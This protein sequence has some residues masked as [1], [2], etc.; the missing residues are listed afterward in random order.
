VIFVDSGVSLRCHTTCISAGNTFH[1]IKSALT[2]SIACSNQCSTTVRTQKIVVGWSEV[3]HPISLNNTMCWTFLYNSC[4]RSTTF[5]SW[6]LHLISITLWRSRSLIPFLWTKKCWN[7]C[8]ID[9]L[10]LIFSSWTTSSCKHNISIFQLFEDQFSNWC[11]GSCHL[12]NSFYQSLWAQ[13]I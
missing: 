5:I 1:F 13:L 11:V 3:C 8:A 6:R 12:T 9:L 10:C 2:F 4:K 7:P